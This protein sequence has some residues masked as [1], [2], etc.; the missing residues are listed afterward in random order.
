MTSIYKSRKQITKRKL[1]DDLLISFP[2]WFPF[3]YIFFVTNFPSITKVFFITSLFLFAETH[4]ASTWLFFFDKGNW[5]WLRKNFYNLA[6]LPIYGVFFLTVIWFFEPSVILII[7]YLT[8]LQF[9]L[10]QL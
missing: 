3:T 5:N 1:L 10:P 6:F 8:V 4:F 9:Q 2:C 7:H